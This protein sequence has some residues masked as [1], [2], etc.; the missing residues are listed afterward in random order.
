MKVSF[1]PNELMVYP[2]TDFERQLLS[3]FRDSTSFLKCGLTPADVVGYVI[4]ATINLTTHDPEIEDFGAGMGIS[5]P[6]CESTQI[7]KH[8]NTDQHIYYCDECKKEWTI[9]G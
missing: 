7:W 9:Q 6:E 4:R 3:Q 1:R 8:V 5:C 2:E